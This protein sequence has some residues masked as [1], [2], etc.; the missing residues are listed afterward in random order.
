MRI[1]ITIDIDIDPLKSSL[2]FFETDPKLK[3]KD[4]I[5]IEQRQASLK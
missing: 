5:S 3:L 4:T 2:N 1:K